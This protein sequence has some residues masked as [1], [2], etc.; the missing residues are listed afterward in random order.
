VLCDT[1]CPSENTTSKVRPWGP[2]SSSVRWTDRLTDG[3]GAGT[4]FGA[5]TLVRTAATV[6]TRAGAAVVTGA[7]TVTDVDA[8]ATAEDVGAAAEDDAPTGTVAPVAFAV[9]PPQP[10]RERA[11]PTA[12]AAVARRPVRREE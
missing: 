1:T 5:G 12:T 10:A 7:G 8:G 9:C 6:L 3:A 4:G 11:R 2:H